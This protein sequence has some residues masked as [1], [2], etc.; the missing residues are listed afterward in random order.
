MKVALEPRNFLET[1]GHIGRLSLE[2]L[3][4]NTIWLGL[5]HP[6]LQPFGGCRPYTVEVQTG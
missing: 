3:Y 1:A 2:L 5:C 6:G 4:T